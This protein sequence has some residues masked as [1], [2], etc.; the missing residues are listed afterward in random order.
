MSWA[1]TRATRPARNSRSIDRELRRG[2]N[3][4]C[5]DGPAASSRTAAGASRIA[6]IRCTLLSYNRTKGFT[7]LAGAAPT[8]ARCGKVLDGQLYPHATEE[9]CSELTLNP[10]L[11]A[12]VKRCGWLPGPHGM[13]RPGTV[14]PAGRT[15]RSNGGIARMRCVSVTGPAAERLAPVLHDAEEDDDRIRAALRD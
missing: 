5:R 4:C 9:I 10:V 8:P 14:G 7:S 3:L 15:D 11:K 12:T 6:V 13:T 2:W 1:C